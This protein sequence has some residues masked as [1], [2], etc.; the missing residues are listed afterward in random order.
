[1]VI[2]YLGPGWRWHQLWRDSSRKALPCHWS[3]APRGLQSYAKAVRDG[4]CPHRAFQ[5]GSDGEAWFWW[6]FFPPTI[7]FETSKFP[8]EGPEVLTR[9]NPKLVYARLT[10]NTL[11]ALNEHYKFNHRHLYH[12]SSSQSGMIAGQM[13]QVSHQIH[14]QY[15]LQNYPS[16]Q[17]S[18]SLVPTET[19]LATTSTIW[20]SLASS[21]LSEESMRTQ[22][23]QVNSFIVFSISINRLRKG[24]G[25]SWAEIIPCPKE[26]IF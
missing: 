21:A 11:Q 6:V 13:L 19:W 7:S 1:M 15:N 20:Q 5:T 2:T 16:R 26:L 18:D 12:W 22:L 24:E 9:D 25:L 14:L 3:Q 10:G 4:R 23:L 8:L 17:D